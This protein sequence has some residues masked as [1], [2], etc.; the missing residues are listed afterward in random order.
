VDL[1]PPVPAGIPTNNLP[2]KLRNREAGCLF[3]SHCL[4]AAGQAPLL[5]KGEAHDTHSHIAFHHPKLL[6]HLDPRAL[7]TSKPPLA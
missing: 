4:W 1:L 2:G 5:T 3:H 6:G 7:L